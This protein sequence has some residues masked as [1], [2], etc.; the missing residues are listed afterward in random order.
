ME[1]RRTLFDKLDS[2][3]IP[4]TVKQKLFNK[5]NIFTFESNCL[6]D[7]TFM[8]TEKATWIGKHLPA[9]VSMSS[10][11]MQEPSF[12]CDPNPCDLV[13]VSIDA[14]EK[15]AT[16]EEAQMKMNFLQTETAKTDLHVS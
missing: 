3:G 14:L 1:T 15:L 11:L 4:Y 6:E 7:E 8:D 13:S 10:N 16:Q 5:M 12:P 2:F 9:S